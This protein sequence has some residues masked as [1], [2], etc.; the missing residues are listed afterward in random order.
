M[1]DFKSPRAFGDFSCYFYVFEI[2]HH[3]VG[4]KDG[5]YY[6]LWDAADSSLY[7]YLS[8]PDSG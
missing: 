2:A 6:D 5:K 8:S 1:I 4:L 3:L 7:G